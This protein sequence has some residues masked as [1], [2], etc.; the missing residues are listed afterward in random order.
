MNIRSVGN[1]YK[2]FNRCVLAF[3]ASGCAGAADFKVQN[4]NRSL[5]ARDNETNESINLPVAKTLLLVAVLRVSYAG[6]YVS[7]KSE[8]QV[9]KAMRNEGHHP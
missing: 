9:Q 6:A 2:S 5:K 7:G 1:L 4:L 3:V 8:H